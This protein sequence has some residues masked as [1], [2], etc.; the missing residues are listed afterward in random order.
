MNLLKADKKFYGSTEYT[1]LLPA[2]LGL[3]IIV[4]VGSVILILALLSLGV[5]AQTIGWFIDI[6]V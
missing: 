1:G 6:W 4:I 5:L 3:S 2:L